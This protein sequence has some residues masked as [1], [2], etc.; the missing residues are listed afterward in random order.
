M[1]CWKLGLSAGIQAINGAKF[2]E[3][4]KFQSSGM[5]V[6]CGWKKSDAA[7]DNINVPLYHMRY[8]SS[9]SICSSQELIGK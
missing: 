2:S 8:H 1:M 5:A 6:V 3:F 7:M 4:E 9:E